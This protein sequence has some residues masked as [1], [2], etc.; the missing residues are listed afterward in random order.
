MKTFVH[1]ILTTLICFV[2][3]GVVVQGIF[4]VIGPDYKEGKYTMTYRVHYP[5]YPKE[6]TIT[7]NLPISISS[8]RGVNRVEKTH[9][10]VPFKKIYS[11]ETIFETTAPI[12]IVSYTYKET[13]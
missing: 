8:Y 12:E 3:V 9:E 10:E 7:N 13:K 6:Y 2:I 11:T 4:L 5:N 1:I